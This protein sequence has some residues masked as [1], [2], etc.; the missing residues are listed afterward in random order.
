MEDLF[1]TAARHRGGYI[2]R[3]DLL[4]MGL[5]DRDIRDGLRSGLIVR[6]R[7]GTYAPQS[8]T[9]LSLAQR[10][11]L[12]AYSVLDRLPSDAVLS[13]HSASVIHTGTDYGLDLSTVHVTRM[14]G[15]HGRCE[16]GVA[17]HVGAVDD[18][19]ITTT[20]G[21]R[22]IVAERSVLE[23]SALAG[24]DAGMV[25][26]SFALR[27]RADIDK[28]HAYLARMERWPKLAKVRLAVRWA[29]PQCESV[30]EIRSVHMFR[31]GGLPLPE[32]QVELREPSGKLLGRVDFD[33][34]DYGH[35]GEFDG[36]VKYGRLN[37]HS[38]T[39]VGQSLV[40]E[41]RR[42]DRIRGY[43]RGMS[44]WI[45]SDLSRPADTCKQIFA[46]MEQSRRLY[47]RARTIIA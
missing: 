13:H 23:S 30:G 8:V 35:C 34:D 22:L 41:K 10:H 31:L 17:H 46:A 37:P 40:Q 26:V 44:R 27:A 7:V 39:E 3:P 9:G 47:R 36:L 45:W 18:G 16:A 43:P 12:V 4:D 32:P 1:S 29:A 42:E 19:D 2:L 15:R 33:W 24:T 25:Q 14:D 28:L 20:D 5:R 21:R 38:S 11:R 6:L